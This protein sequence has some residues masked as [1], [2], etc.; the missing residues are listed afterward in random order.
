[1]RVRLRDQGPSREIRKLWQEAGVPVSVRECCPL[2]L[3]NGS[4]FWLIPFGQLSGP[5]P[6]VQRGLTLGW[7]C[8]VGDPRA[9]GA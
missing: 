7:D 8:L 1:M 2:I 5:W 9:I 4:P 6:E 3:V